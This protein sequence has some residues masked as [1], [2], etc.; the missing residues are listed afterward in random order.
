[1]ISDNGDSRILRL[2]N[3]LLQ[4]PTQKDAESKQP[5]TKAYV[6]AKTDDIVRWYM[7]QVQELVGAMLAQALTSYDQA[8][9][10]AFE[11][12]V[13]GLGED[14][15]PPE[16]VEKLREVLGL[17]NVIAAAENVAVE[18]PVPE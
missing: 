6:I 14:G 10:E 18:P 15:V 7:S 1:M 2:E 16:W 12:A 3:G 5:A 17:P 8:K 11:K 9:R 13:S 4:T